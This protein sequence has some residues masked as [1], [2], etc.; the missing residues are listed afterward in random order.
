MQSNLYITNL[1]YSIDS[2]A[3]RAHFGSCG[4]VVAA[5][6][7]I[8]RDTGRSRGFG[9]VEMGTQEQAQKAIETLNDQPLGGRALG[10]ALA[11]PR[12]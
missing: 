7:I 8:D 5:D 11:R 6:V 10:V 1:G 12:K 2:E 4:D 9:F 3:L